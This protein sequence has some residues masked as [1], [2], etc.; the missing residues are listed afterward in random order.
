MKGELLTAIQLQPFG[1][2][3]ITILP[4][5]PAAAMPASDGLKAKLHWQGEN[6]EVLPAGSVAVA[7]TTPPA[8][9][10][11]K[12]GNVAVIAALPPASVVTS[13]APMKNCPSPLLEA[14]QAA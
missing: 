10:V 7:V 14:S 9:S 1:A 8:L 13:V 5:L 12:E 6:S 2:F 11:G 4:V 3:T